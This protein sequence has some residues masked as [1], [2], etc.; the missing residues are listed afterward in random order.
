MYCVKCKSK[1]SDA[2]KPT[3]VKTKNGRSMAT[4]KCAT[5]GTKKCQFV[6][7][8]IKGNALFNPGNR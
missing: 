8:G 7:G 5:C 3:I 1:T 4:T 2:S 6:K